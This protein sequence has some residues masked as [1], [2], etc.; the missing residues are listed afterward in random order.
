MLIN[1]FKSKIHRA[2][3]T[4]ANVDYEGS[5]KI[6]GLLLD[7]AKI[8]EYEQIHL[9]DVTNGKRLVTYVLRGEEGSGC[10]EING[11]GALLMVSHDLLIAATFCSM[12]PDEANYHKPT[13]VLVDGSNKITNIVNE[14]G[15]I[16]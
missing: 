16:K 14:S 11:A 15:G 5:I 6:D 1:M 4:G 8:R 2:T 13:V 7:A 12:Y 3:I 10:F 9:W